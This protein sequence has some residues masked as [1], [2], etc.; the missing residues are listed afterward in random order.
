MNSRF[1]LPAKILVIRDAE[2]NFRIPRNP[3]GRGLL[4][5]DIEP[6][7]AR[8]G[9]IRLSIGDVVILREWIHG[10]GAEVRNPLRSRVALIRRYSGQHLPLRFFAEMPAVIPARLY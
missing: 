6:I 3:H 5:S 1:R 8:P 9:R 7:R 10:A 2:A 4:P